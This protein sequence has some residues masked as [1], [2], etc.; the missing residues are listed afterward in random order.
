[1]DRSRASVPQHS[2]AVR[3]AGSAALNLLP[4][5]A[6]GKCGEPATAPQTRP[7]VHEAPVLWQPQNG[8]ASEKSRSAS[9][10]LD[11]RLEDDRRVTKKQE[12]VHCGLLF[13]FAFPV[14]KWL[15]RS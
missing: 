12:D 3:T 7:V 4:P 9:F 13:G 5:A 2:T 10:R 1:M 14:T 11:G 15:L 6:A 8:V